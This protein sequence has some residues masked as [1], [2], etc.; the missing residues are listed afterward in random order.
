[1]TFANPFFHFLIYIRSSFSKVLTTKQSVIVMAK[2]EILFGN[3]N[4]R[5]TEIRK[6]GIISVKFNCKSC[7]SC[8]LFAT[9]RL[10]SK[11]LIFLHY[12]A[13]YTTFSPL[14]WGSVLNDGKLKIAIIV[15]AEKLVVWNFE[16]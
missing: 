7:C 16:L 2:F 10:T 13:F 3:A 12:K 14:F 6:K 1:M 5:C 15:K 11:F 4:L 8:G 9:K